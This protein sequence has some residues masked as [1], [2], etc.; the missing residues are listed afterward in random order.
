MSFRIYKLIFIIMIVT[1][2]IEISIIMISSTFDINKLFNP[3]MYNYSFQYLIS[4]LILVAII[5]IIIVAFAYYTFIF[6][7]IFYK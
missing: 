2:I 7:R 6:P 1:L 3:K 4:V 5:F